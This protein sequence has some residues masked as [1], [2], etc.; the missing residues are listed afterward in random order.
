MRGESRLVLIACYLA[1][2][3]VGENSTAIMAALP[4]MSARLGLGRAEVEWAVNAYLL[5]SAAF[6]ILGGRAADGFGAR[7][8]SA[9]GVLLFALASLIIAL[10]PDGAAVIAARALQGLGAAFAVAGSLAAV[11]EA[12]P[13]A[14]RAAA[15]SGW[16][17]FLMLGFSIGPLLGGAVTHYAGW[18]VVF[19][20][21]LAMMLPAG[22]AL[23]AKPGA[24]G[25]EA[26]GV[27]WPGLGLLVLFMVTMVSGLQALA[28]FAQAP[29][30][31]ILLLLVA[32][33]ALLLLY[34]TERRRDHPL[35]DFALFQ[36][37]RF[38]L[39]VLIASLMM[40]DIMTLLL[41]YNLFAQSLRGL[42]LTPIAAGLSLVPLSV[43]LFGFARV[44]P[45]IAEAV[46]LRRMMVGGGLI[47]V[48]GC[49]IAVVSLAVAGPVLRVIGLFAIGAGIALPYATAPRL[50]L[51]AL[52]E[53]EAGQGS[54]V[55]SACTFLSATIG[56]TGGGIV[57]GFAGFAG[58]LLLVALAALASAALS[59][60]I[61]EK[62]RS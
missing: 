30:D 51:A 33:V 27:D 55:I 14:G 45:R 25:R 43:A 17:G 12:V 58:V 29:W 62:A 11:A 1:I 31:A 24:P 23:A 18:R 60:R 56:V 26:G 49:A 32:V 42:A 15:I 5:A 13:E 53:T 44:A 28:R 21:N 41:Y 52:P 40:F 50:G 19:S 46:G 48:L 36:N 39:A 61:K 20:L 9:A 2:F 47:L 4:A 37:R 10:A 54:G 16:T 35:L 59:L 7:R 34:R 3:A 6:I 57:S 8:S 22:L 38:T